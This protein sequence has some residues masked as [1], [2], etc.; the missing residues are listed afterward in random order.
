MNIKSSESCFGNI[1]FRNPYLMIA[2]AQIYF[3]KIS[4]TLESIYRVIR[5]RQRVG[6]ANGEFIQTLVI[7]T[8]SPSS[9]L[10]LGQ[11]DRSALRRFVVSDVSHPQIFLDLLSNFILFGST[12]PIW[13]YAHRFSAWNQ[14]YLMIYRTRRR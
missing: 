7:Y 4:C 12:Q 10:L 2:S 9:I 11:D 5:T 6:I 8:H 3:S 14:V 1:F 13:G